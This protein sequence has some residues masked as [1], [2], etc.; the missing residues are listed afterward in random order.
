[1]TR[2]LYKFKVCMTVKSESPNWLDVKKGVNICMN[3]GI[4]SELSCIKDVRFIKP[5]KENKEIL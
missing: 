4:E 1:M 3:C 2:K 5:V